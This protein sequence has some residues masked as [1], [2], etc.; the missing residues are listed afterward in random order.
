RLAREQRGTVSSHGLAG[1]R[2]LTR[3]ALL[4]EPV[5]APLDVFRR[6]QALL[7]PPPVHERAHFARRG[8]GTPLGELAW[9]FLW[10]PAARQRIARWLSAPDRSGSGLLVG[11]GAPGAGKLAVLGNGLL[12]SYPEIHGLIAPSGFPGRSW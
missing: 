9:H 4:P 8:L 6:L 7:A 3:A 11:T 12:H 5:A 10:R 2:R 1:V